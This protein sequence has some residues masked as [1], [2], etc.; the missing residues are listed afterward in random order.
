MNCRGEVRLLYVE[1]EEPSF[2]FL[3]ALTDFGFVVDICKSREEAEQYLQKSAHALKSIVLDLSIP[4][5]VGGVART[6][7]GIGLF[8]DV[9]CKVVP[10][11][12]PVCVL[13]GEADRD[14]LAKLERA[15]SEQNR[16]APRTAAKPLRNV[17]AFCSQTWLEIV[18]CRPELEQLAPRSEMPGVL[19]VR[20]PDDGSGQPTELV[21]RSKLIADVV[22]FIEKVARSGKLVV[23]LGETGVGK[24]LFARAL[25]R[26]SDRSSRPMVS[27]VIPQ[28]AA[29][30]VESELFGIEPDVATGVRGR[31]GYFESADHGTL[32][33]DEFGEISLEIQ[34]KL[35]DALQS[36]RIQRMGA[37]VPKYVDVRVVAATNR[38]LEA[39]MREGRFR[40]DLYY[41][42]MGSEVT[43][44]PLRQRREELLPRVRFSLDRFERECGRHGE[45]QQ[46]K[47]EQKTVELLLRHPWP[48]NGHELDRMISG[49]AVASEG[50]AEFEGRLQEKLQGL[51][52]R[53]K[54]LAG[55]AD[56]KGED[57]K[58]D[59]CV[60]RYGIRRELLEMKGDDFLARC[61]KLYVAHVEERFGENLHSN[62]E[63]IKKETELPYSRLLDWKKGGRK[64]EQ[65]QSSSTSASPFEDN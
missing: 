36:G 4:E 7:V 32:F 40:S 11:A 16:A 57:A 22:R 12:V 51:W 63:V 44:P 39:M 59:A 58:E 26:M 3:H 10:N 8:T 64:R 56:G 45:T 2:G 1:D 38:D 43:I 23:L 28:I 17:E 52:A 41:R 35:L 33:L 31:P 53:V 24:G 54:L 30:L 48:G 27:V 46:W 37:R 25:H 55:L 50:N 34:S 6:A 13:S 21:Y 62:E 42:L 9:V 5:R 15:A 65:G 60:E 18:R 14:D 29:T 20:L 61:R 19:S 49:L 47:L